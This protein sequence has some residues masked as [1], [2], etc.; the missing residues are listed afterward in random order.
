M[1][2][3][4]VFL[5]GSIEMGA[6][7]DW[8]TDMAKFFLERDWN[9]FNPRRPDWDSTWQQDIENPQFYQQVK[10]ELNALRK[11]DLII[12]Y[13]VPGTISPIS[14]MEFGKY[15]GSG[16]MWVV[17]PDG[18]FRKGNVDIVSEEDNNP[19]FTSLDELKEHFLSQGF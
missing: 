7:I 14:L 15:S 17:C 3:R 19:V 13:L 6:A 2:R 11:S 12:M 10:W 1:N 4:S 16:K 5:G 8:Q 9:V 18:Y